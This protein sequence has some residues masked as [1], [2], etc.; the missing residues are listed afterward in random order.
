[1]AT[2]QQI[3]DKADAKLVEFWSALTTKQDAYFAKHGRYFQLVITNPVIDGTD[4]TFEV[5]HP[6]EE[7][8]LADA[9]FEF[10]S[11]IPFQIYVDEWTQK[12]GAAGYYATVVVE[13][14]NG[15]KYRRSRTHLND[16]T[17]WLAV[18][19]I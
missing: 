6:E 12:D 7:P 5:K 4:T 1:M 18:T 17:G 9:N 14:L 16:D 2:L 10:N 3:R 15:D 11:P 19:E 8:H 13:L